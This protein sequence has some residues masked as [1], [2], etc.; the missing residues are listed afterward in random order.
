MEDK[1]VT[2]LMT[3]RARAIAAAYETLE[4]SEAPFAV[5]VLASGSQGNATLITYKNTT[6]LVDAGISA[7]RIT[8]GLKAVGLGLDKLSAICIT[9]EH[10]D[11]MAGLPQL[12]KQCNVPVYTRAGT[13]R[14]PVNRKNLDTKAF[15]VLTKN[16]FTIGDL[17]IETFRT[18]HDAADPMGLSCYNGKHKLT[19][20]TDTGLVDDTMLKNMDE[21]DLLVL[22]AN[23]DPQMLKY[24]PYPFDLKK[25][26]AGPYGHLSNEHAAQALL[27]M[28]CPE[29]LQVVMAHRSE[30]NNE[31]AV[32]T[33]TVTT[34]LTAEG[35]I[36][37]QDITIFHGQPKE[38]V[39]I[40]A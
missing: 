24:G 5:H 9:H 39:T 4:S 12:L 23:Y 28:K 22:E 37:K 7:R 34:A 14:E 8:N 21:S 3:D 35:L 16:N 1:E 38:M 25:R 6:I 31:Q 17:Q 19:F 29:H 15:C 20:M 26:V 32:V 13:M 36:M 40:R 27:M 18:S 33:D 30:K 11:H 2:N 10:T